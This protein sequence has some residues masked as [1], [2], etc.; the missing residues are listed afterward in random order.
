M[1]DAA[2]LLSNRQDNVLDDNVH[3]G[4]QSVLDSLFSILDHCEQYPFTVIQVRMEC[5][6]CLCYDYMYVYVLM[7][8]MC[9]R[10]CTGGVP[11]GV[12]NIAFNSARQRLYAHWSFGRI[13]RRFRV[14]GYDLKVCILGMHVIVM[15]YV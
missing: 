13:R 10:G 15:M 11:Y 12:W 4:D 14:C 1:D 5:G 6:M 8:Y 7:V 3:I 9:M 2:L